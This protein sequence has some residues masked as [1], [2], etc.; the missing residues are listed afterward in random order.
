MRNA[1]GGWWRGLMASRRRI[2]ELQRL[3]PEAELIAKD[4]GL[5]PS[6]LYAIAA[7]RPDA[8]ALLQRRLDAL[9]IER[10]KTAST[11]LAILRDLDR[12]CSVCG[13]KRRCERDLAD[14]G[15]GRPAAGVRPPS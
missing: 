1:I 7:K 9:H 6:A 15:A 4:V 13:S 5:S 2:E 11:D 8:A 14:L 10:A 12:V 3:G